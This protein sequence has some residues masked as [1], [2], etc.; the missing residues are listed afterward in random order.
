MY[1]LRAVGE[2]VVRLADNASI[3]A[4]PANRDWIQYQAWRKIK[5]NEPAAADPNPKGEELVDVL[6][7]KGIIQPGDVKRTNQLER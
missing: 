6:I 2:G 4:D 3:P 1:K 7:R 5:G